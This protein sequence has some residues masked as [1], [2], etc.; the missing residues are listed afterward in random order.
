MFHIGDIFD[1]GWPTVSRSTVVGALLGTASAVVCLLIFI[2]ELPQAFGLIP[3]IGLTVPSL[4]AGAFTGAILG[5]RSCPDGWLESQTRPKID[6]QPRLDHEEPELA[7]MPADHENARTFQ[8][9]VA[10]SNR[11]GHS[12]RSVLTRH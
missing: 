9:R 11:S 6:L 10:E 12:P 3:C 7:V 4:L 5:T 1:G 8:D 2:P